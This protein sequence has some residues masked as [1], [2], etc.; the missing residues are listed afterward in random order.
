MIRSTSK[1]A[2]LASFSVAVSGAVAAAQDSDPNAGTID[3][4][5]LNDVWAEMDVY[6]PAYTGQ[7]AST[8]TAVG[9]N[10]AAL[11]ISGD[12]SSEISQDFDAS[13]SAVN[14]LRGYAA[15]TALATTTAYGN[16]SSG[17]TDYGN[18]TYRAQQ[19]AAGSIDAQTRVE[20]AGAYDGAAAT[21]A[22]ANVSSTDNNFGESDTDQ[23]QQSAANVS[24]ET[25]ADMAINGYYASFATTAGANATSAT[26][27]TSTSTNRARQ[28]TAAGSTVQASTD[29]YMQDGTNVSSVTNAFGNSATV[30]NEWGYATLGQEG[31][32]TEQTNG[33][34]VDAQSWVTLD[35]WSGY[36]T[37]SAYGVGNS[38]LISNVGS[39]TVMYAN[40]T[41]DGTVGSQASF[42]GQS[43]T[44]GTGSVA[45]TSIGNAATATVC[46]YCSDAAVGGR[47]NQTNNGQVYAYGQASS[48][49][50][51]AIT[52]SATAIGNAATIQSAGD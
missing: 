20:L 23:V 12:V 47:V 18:N 8:S 15:G 30:N 2:L 14:G 13:A 21:T 4:V 45:A 42:S 17:G 1:I 26:G 38:A 40:Q 29:V 32:P 5:Q 34:D 35:Q 43:W 51:N 41:N 46:N 16:A 39:D 22:I 52:G 6:V 25:D 33:A 11:R 44:G 36:A 3:Q 31:A 50:G 24:A 49:Y 9:N 37:S 27:Y 19:N 7:A 10:A 28:T 48:T